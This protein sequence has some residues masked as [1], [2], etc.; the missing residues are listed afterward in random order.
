MKEGREG[1]LQENYLLLKIKQ[2][3]QKLKR[4]TEM[5]G[6]NRNEQGEMNKL[7]LTK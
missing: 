1:I 7:E 4:V 5:R 6:R 3:Q 2:K